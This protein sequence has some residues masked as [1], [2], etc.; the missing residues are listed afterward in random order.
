VL[1]TCTKNYSL[2]YAGR[3]NLKK[4]EFF[5][6]L[7]KYVGSKRIRIRK[8]VKSRIRIWIRYYLKVGSGSA[9][10][11]KVGSQSGSDPLLIVSNPQRCI[12]RY[13]TV[14]VSLPDLINSR[15]YDLK[16]LSNEK[17]GGSCLV[18]FD[19]Y[20]FNLHFRNIFSMF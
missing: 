1:I 11:W 3:K 15:N 9:I 8:D 20:W 18:S 19:R 7:K 13:S 6:H 17:K 5:F 14:P 16:V 12:L 10:Y 2:P 4:Y